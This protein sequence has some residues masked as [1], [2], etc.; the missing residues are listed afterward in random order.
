LKVWPKTGAGLISVSITYLTRSRSARG[1]MPGA[2]GAME[3]RS[4]KVV[5]SPLGSRAEANL[6]WRPHHPRQDIERGN[7]YLRVLFVQA[8]WVVLIKPKSWERHGLKHWIEAAKKRLHRN[9]QRLLNRR[10]SCRPPLCLIE[11]PSI[12][13]S[14]P[15]LFAHLPDIPSLP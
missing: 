15:E 7:R 4:P 2:G 12:A 1:R 13:P 11:A 3:M 8:A 14:F 6:N 5:T 9:V 10:A